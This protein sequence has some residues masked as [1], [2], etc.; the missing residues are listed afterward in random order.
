MGRLI[1]RASALVAAG[2]VVGTLGAAGLSAAGLSAAGAATLA[3]QPARAPSLATAHGLAVPGAKLWVRRFS[4]PGKDSD[5]AS[6]VAVSQGGG[7][8]FVTGDSTDASFNSDYLTVAYNAATGARLWTARYNGLGNSIDNAR[9]V[10]VSPDGATVFVTGDSVAGPESGHSDDYATVAYRASDGTQLWVARFNGS[11]NSGDF[12]TAVS[13]ARDSSAVFVTGTSF[14]GGF[15]SVSSMTTV[16]FRASDGAQLWVKSWSPPSC[17]NYGGT[18]IVSPGG[19]RV[20]VTGLVQSQAVTAEYGTVAYN[21]TTGARLW[22]RRFTGQGH[23]NYGTVAYSARTGARLWARF[24]GGRRSTEFANS[25]AVSPGGT[26]LVTGGSRG[27][28]GL[29][30]DYATV[31]YSP[32][33]SQLWVRRYSGPGSHTD[34][35]DAVAVPGNGRVYVTGTSWGGSATGDDYATIAYNVRSGV[36]LWVR[37]YNGP[38]SGADSAMALAARGGRVFVTGGSAGTTSGDDYATIAYTS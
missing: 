17:C 2:A 33:G 8:V 13:V 23:F 22:S 31:A 27:R 38:A 3:P 26:V 28:A 35:A 20:F 5:V 15:D 19:N 14:L 12:A 24:Y 21:A 16:A 6:S 11:A 1:A 25:V 36:Q 4:G 30:T 7:R 29:N 37:R 18:A 32:G 10:A 34:I 9:A